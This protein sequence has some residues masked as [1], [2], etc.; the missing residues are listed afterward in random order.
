MTNSALQFLYNPSQCMSEVAC[1]VIWNAIFANDNNYC[2]KFVWI[3]S[4]VGVGKHDFVDRL[5]NEAC[6]KEN[7]DYDFELSNAIIRNIQIKEINSDL[8]ELR[9]AQR[10]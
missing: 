7:I 1:N 6:R 5:V 4:H 10:P 2:I 8:E 9:N 3:P